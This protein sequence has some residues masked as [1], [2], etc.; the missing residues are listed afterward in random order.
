[1]EASAFVD[2]ALR[3]RGDW[4]SALLHNARSKIDDARAALVD[5]ERVLHGQ[6][7]SVAR[8][9]AK[10]LEL[11]RQEIARLATRIDELEAMRC[12]NS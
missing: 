1:M 3:A 4:R 11:R 6:R 7:D 5:G 8:L 12:G 2:E 10:H 9:M